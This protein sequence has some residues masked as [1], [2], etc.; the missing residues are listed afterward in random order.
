VYQNHNAHN[1]LKRSVLAYTSDVS[2]VE[3]LYIVLESLRNGYDLLWRFLPHWLPTVIVFEQYTPGCMFELWSL[4]GLSG[5]WLDLLVETGVRWTG[6]KLRV[7]A[8]MKDKPDLLE[9]LSTAIY[10]EFEFIKLSEGRWASLGLSCRSLAAALV[11]GAE[12]LTEYIA[13]QPHVT[14][15][16]IGGFRK[17]LSQ[18]VRNLV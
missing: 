17:F 1:G 3:K 13:A 18:A 2:T 5:A 7:S 11:V 4:L 15:H 16:Y 12:A 6:G 14:K 9:L 10:G 8:A